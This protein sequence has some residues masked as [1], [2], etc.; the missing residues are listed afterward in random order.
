MYLSRRTIGGNLYMEPKQF[1]VA[2]LSLKNCVVMLGTEDE[3]GALR[4][5]QS[6]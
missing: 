1:S 4:D 5:H 3:V 6:M 2:L